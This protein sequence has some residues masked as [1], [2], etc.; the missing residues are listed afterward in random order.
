MRIASPPLPASPAAPD[1]AEAGGLERAWRGALLASVALLPF[2]GVLPDPWPGAPVRWS[3]LPLA[4]ALVFFAL[5]RGP[6]ALL[7]PSPWARA[8]LGYGGWVVVSWWA[9]ADVATGFK[10]AGVLSLVGTAFLAAAFA[11]PARL[12]RVVALGVIGSAGFAVAGLLAHA[13]GF[14]TALVGWSGDLLPGAWARPRAGSTHP[15]LAASFALFAFGVVSAEA[16]PRLRRVAQACAALVAV[17]TFSRALFSLLALPWL[18]AGGR[19]ARIAA[20]GVA[21]TLVV[22]TLVRVDLDPSQPWNAR[23]SSEPSPRVITFS[24]AVDA[25]RR[26]PLTG[27]GPGVD[28]ANLGGAPFHAHN[29]A[30]S[31]AASYGLPAFF[32]F[33]AAALGVLRGAGDRW[34]RATLAALLL[35]GLAAD[36]EDFRHFW[37]A[38]GLAA[39]RGPGPGAEPRPFAA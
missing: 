24:T 17:T 3:D 11:A 36:V 35:D 5:A 33:A 37:L 21:A 22:L 8:S 10:A 34:A 38:L 31:V 32:L 26:S 23:L 19:R 18:M 20:A 1:A 39:P 16:S 12:A 13:A 30:V 7:Q 29:T 15:N 2:P 14:E 6:R 27:V 9:H 4:L 25:L 28:P